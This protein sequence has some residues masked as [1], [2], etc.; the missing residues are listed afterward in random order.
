[1]QYAGYQA[2]AGNYVVIDGAG[3]DTDYVYMHMLETP[4]VETGDRVFTGQQLGEVG[5]TGR[6]SGCHL[7]FE[8]WSGPGWYEG[9]SAFDPLPELTRWDA[10]S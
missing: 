3:S 10:Y 9:G 5:E 2:A 4:L 8:M 6:A 1:V 7:H